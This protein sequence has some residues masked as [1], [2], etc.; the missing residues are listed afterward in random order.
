MV[1]GFVDAGGTRGDG[2]GDGDGGEDFDAPIDFL[3]RRDGSGAVAVADRKSPSRGEPSQHSDRSNKSAQ[4]GFGADA[5]G[6]GVVFK[7]HLDSGDVLRFR[8]LADE[9]TLS[10]VVSRAEISLQG[11]RKAPRD[12][13]TATATAS[14]LDAKTT[15]LTYED[16]EGDW[17]VLVGDGDLREA[18]SL[19]TRRG[20]APDAS[21]RASHVHLK[22]DGDRGAAAAAGGGAF[23]FASTPGDARRRGRVRGL[24]GSWASAA[25]AVGAHETT[26]TVKASVG[27]DVVR[28][29]LPPSA[30]TFEDVAS[31]IEDSLDDGKRV[32]RFK[33]ADESDETCVLAGD[34]DLDECRAAHALAGKSTMRLHCELR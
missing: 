30:T 20:A 9:F 28:F 24:G 12:G 34:A 23:A 27:R 31:R 8:M 21:P 32:L 16:D 3:D 4:M 17:C 15:R 11:A 1:K 19:A 14:S 29:T 6:G 13:E 25:F 10:D 26:F 22:L 5:G 2:D 33:Y 18:V 7:L